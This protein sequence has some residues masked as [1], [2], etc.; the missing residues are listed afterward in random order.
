M[1]WVKINCDACVSSL[2]HKSGAGGI[3]R[4]P[5]TFLAAWSKPYPDVTDPL[6]AEALA[7]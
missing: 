6:I 2:Q 5:T 4:T 7:L 1:D 3:A